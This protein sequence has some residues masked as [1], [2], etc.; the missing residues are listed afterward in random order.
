MDA[1]LALWVGQILLALALLVVGYSHSLG[2]DQAFARRA[3]AG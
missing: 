1:N 2:F 3:W